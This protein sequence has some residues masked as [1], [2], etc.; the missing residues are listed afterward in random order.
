VTSE[1]LEKLTTGVS[2][3]VRL[4]DAYSDCQAPLTKAQP[5]TNLLD[6]ILK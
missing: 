5:A 6:E 2:S 1:E 3:L 4:V